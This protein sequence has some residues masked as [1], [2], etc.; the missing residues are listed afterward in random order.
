MFLNTSGQHCDK[1]T[2][3][4]RRPF[5]LYTSYVIAQDEI[6]ADNV[7]NTP[8]ELMAYI[9]M[10]YYEK[11]LSYGENFISRKYTNREDIVH[12]AI[13]NVMAVAKKN[14]DKIRYYEPEH[15]KNWLYKAMGNR[16]RQYMDKSDRHYNRHTY[17]P[18]SD[19]ESINADSPFVEWEVDDTIESTLMELKRT[20][21]DSIDEVV[22]QELFINELS[23]RE[24]AEKHDLPPGVVRGRSYRMREKLK[25]I[26]K[27]FFS[28]IA[29]ILVILTAI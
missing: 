20:L 17:M 25:K 4:D 2:K 29:C 9:F 23:E 3:V 7:Y 18:A 6:G 11:L 19:V 5:S 15:L 16:L 12:D 27:T 10:T 22:Y 21:K 26:Y 14:F 24:I 28:I 1:K 13:A 8:E